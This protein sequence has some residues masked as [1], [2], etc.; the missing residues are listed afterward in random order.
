[1]SPKVLLGSLL[2]VGISS[3]VAAEPVGVAQPADLLASVIGTTN[4]VQSISRLDP[5]TGAATALYSP[6]GAP[7]DIEF[8]EDGALFLTTVAGP[9]LARLD[10]ATD[11]LTTIGSLGNDLVLALEFAEGQLYG[12]ADSAGNQGQG[13]P[14]RLVIL[15]PETAAVFEIAVL[16]YTSVHGL[17]YDPRIDTMYGVGVPFDARGNTAAELFTVD[18]NSGATTPIGNVGSA[19]GSLEL[20]PDGRLYAGQL[21]VVGAALLT[22]DP[23]TGA[24]Q[25]SVPTLQTSIL[26]LSFAPGSRVALEVPTL[27]LR[28]LLLLV[29]LVAGLGALV[30][31]RR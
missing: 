3:A 20:G 9:A 5:G 11:Q 23:Q 4:L 19:L 26:G 31:R 28:G 18:L 10:L 21:G 24:I 22:L 14:S 25:S 6:A 13:A 15:D 2:A 16:D 7:L 27:G 17:A 1:M 12:A 8:R 30:L 29:T